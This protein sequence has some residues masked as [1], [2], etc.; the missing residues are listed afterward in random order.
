VAL[1]LA[2]LGAAGFIALR[3]DSIVLLAIGLAMTGGIALG[4]ILRNRL[5][6]ALAAF[7]TTFGP[8][9]FFYIV[10]VAYAGLAFWLVRTGR[11]VTDVQDERG[12]RR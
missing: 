6:T 8:W 10:G 11:Q 5:A 9:S 3:L 1:A 12:A 7:I 4:A 2:A